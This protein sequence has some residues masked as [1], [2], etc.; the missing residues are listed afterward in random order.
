MEFVESYRPLVAVLVSLAAVPLIVASDR[1][2]NLRETWTLIAAF[3][4]AALVVSMLPFVLDDKILTCALWELSPD[5]R[6]ELRVDPLGLIFALVASVLWVFTSF[7]SIGYVRGAREHKQTR[8]FASF[9]VCVSATIGIAFAA[10]LLTFLVFFEMLTFATFPLVIHKETPVAKAAAWKYLAYTIPAGLCL[11][12]ATA[13]SVSLVGDTTFRPGGFLAESGASSGAFG[14]LFLLF[15]LAVGV[16]AGIM[17]L[18]SWLPS[19]MAAPTPVS[20]LLH[21][22]AV[23]KAGV[24]GVLRVTGYVFGT[25]LLRE[26]GAW[27]V[28]A[29]AAGIT[30]TVA[31]L[32]AMRQDNL[33]RRLAYS[34][35]GHLSY[36]VLGAALLTPAAWTGAVLHLL[37]HATMKITLFFCAGAI[38]VRTRK[39]NISQLDG[40]GRQMPITMAAF[41]IASLGLAGVPGVNGFLSK[42]YLALGALEADRQVFLLLLVLSGVLNAAYFFP[43]IRVAFFRSGDEFSRFGEASALMVAPLAI[44][45]LIS[46]TL[47][48]APNLGPAAFDLARGIAMAVAGGAP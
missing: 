13:W 34:T 31:S 43:V 25:D 32:L 45:A 22:V 38:Y 24:F 26:L 23:V 5:I 17:P 21:A 19:A 12:T 20:A 37:F 10:N 18:H 44:T 29:W 30:L 33:K 1:R 40:I 42:W 8:Y 14:W 28:L 27:S 35:V 6:L 41:T 16:K 7:Y 9:A 48:L 39:E 2:P 36:I 3:A 4:K 46:V 15:I 11:I 47:G